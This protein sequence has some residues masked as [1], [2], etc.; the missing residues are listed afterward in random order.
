MS[1]DEVEPVELRHHRF[2]LDQG[3]SDD[4][5]QQGHPQSCD[6][7]VQR[8]PISLAPFARRVL[9]RGNSLARIARLLPR[10]LG[11]AFLECVGPSAAMAPLERGKQR[12]CS[13]DTRGALDFTGAYATPPGDINAFPL[14]SGVPRAGLPKTAIWNNELTNSRS[15]RRP[16]SRTVAMQQP[17]FCTNSARIPFSGT[18]GKGPVPPDAP[19]AYKS[20]HGLR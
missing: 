15:D 13:G 17:L 8:V 20:Y 3:V 4:R 14:A 9:G 2:S 16:V 1:G 6:H 11:P 19:S 18:K 10:Q 12:R 7:V 5:Q